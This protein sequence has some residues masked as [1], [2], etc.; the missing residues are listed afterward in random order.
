M[1]YDA[2]DYFEHS[3]C[4]PYPLYTVNELFMVTVRSV[5]KASHKAF[6]DE[7]CS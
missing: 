7:S 1:G 4:N 3:A 6:E 2:R 5:W